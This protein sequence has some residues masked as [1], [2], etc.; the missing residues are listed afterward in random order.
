[1]N[2]FDAIHEKARERQLRFLI[3]GGLAINH[4]G[5]S[6]DTSDLDLFISRNDRASWQDLL[7]GLGYSE[8]HDGGSFIQYRPPANTAW[9]VDLMLVQEKTF[10]GIFDESREANLYGQNTRVPSLEHLLA[11]K[12]HSLKNTQAHRYLKDFLD[13]ENLIQLNRLDIKSP[14][15]RELFVKYGSDD[16]YEKISRSLASG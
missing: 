5:Y 16:L 4:Y 9:P 2:L 7:S 3:I 10:A 11:L 8:Y 15:I 12:I 6:R 1:M 14:N 13:V